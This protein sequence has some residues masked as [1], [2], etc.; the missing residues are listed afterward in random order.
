VPPTDRRHRSYLR[1]AITLLLGPDSDPLSQAQLLFALT[2]TTFIFIALLFN[3]IAGTADPRL[4]WI[5]ASLMPVFAWLWYQGRWYGRLRLTTNGILIVLSFV[6]LP[7]NWIFNAGSHGPTLLVSTIALAYSVGVHQR[8]DPVLRLAQVGLL[9]MPAVM[10]AIEQRFPDWIFQYHQPSDRYGDLIISYV[11]CSISLGVLILGQSRRF[12]QELQ[13]ADE[14]AEQLRELARRDSLTQLLNH[15]SILEAVQQRLSDR[16]Q[17]TLYLV[18]IDH[19]K[20]IND[21]YGHQTG[22]VILKTLS[23]LM[24][25]ICAS[26]NAQVGRLGGEEFLLA[27]PGGVDQALA[28]DQ[29]LRR[30]LDQRT[31]LICPM[32][33]SAGIA[34]W[35]PGQSLDRLLRRADTS[36][37]AAKDSGRNRTLVADGRP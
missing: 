29:K 37:Y 32:T 30:A 23:D 25:E 2:V 31:D 21:E 1:R 4:D 28:L 34:E 3:V 12:R 16:L 26:L 36:L 22:D 10:L 35:Q 8:H 24:L 20:R 27:I 11:L 19:F 33:F 14:M 17:V 5:Y 15:H 7:S 9:L 6:A 13:R 18:D